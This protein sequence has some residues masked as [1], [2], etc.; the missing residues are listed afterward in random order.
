MI[1]FAPVEQAA[2]SLSLTPTDHHTIRDFCPVLQS[3]GCR[4]TVAT[5]YSFSPEV[6]EIFAAG[7]RDAAFAVWREPAGI[8]VAD[9]RVQGAAP[10]TRA[11]MKDALQWVSAALDSR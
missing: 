11:G 7:E 1:G 2:G 6:F 10:S 9:L 3:R 4:H 8:V 5:D